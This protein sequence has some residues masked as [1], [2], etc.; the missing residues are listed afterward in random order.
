VNSPTKPLTPITAF[1]AVKPAAAALLAAL[2]AV[3]VWSYWPVLGEMARKWSD[4]PQYSHAYLVPLFSLY[5]LWS[6]P[7][8]P[9]SFPGRPN[10]WG[11]LLLGAGVLLRL[12]G[13]Y[14]YVDWLEA[15][16]LLPTLAG[17]TL[18][19]AGSQALRWAWPGIAYL[20]FMIPLPYRVETALSQPLQRIATLAGTYALQTLGRPAFDEGNVIVVNE[21]RIGVAEACNGLGMLMLFFALAT[22]VAIMARRNWLEKAVIVLSAAP[23]AI[24][25][26]V[27]RVAATSF[28][29]E[30][31]GG[32]WANVFF[33]DLA[34]W[35]M[36]PFALGLLGFELWVL[37]HLVV[38]VQP[39]APTKPIAFIDQPRV[40]APSVQPAVNGTARPGRRSARNGRPTPAGPCER[41]S[42]V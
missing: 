42:T 17:A 35:L 34:G 2:A 32:R 23:V 12:A 7:G 25:A 33:H 10:W 11:V 40:K 8:A 24:A 22:A 3:T 20:V 19:L 21:A 31:V 36:M 5:L 28:L 16:S 26:N 15:V 29:Y 18:L 38:E 37:R 14:A 41:R 6:R 4:D 30:F 1:R 39:P 9:A 13:S 27:T